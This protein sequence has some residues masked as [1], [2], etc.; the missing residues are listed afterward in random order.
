MLKHQGLGK[1]G[2]PLL[3]LGELTVQLKI[4]DKSTTVCIWHLKVRENYYLEHSK[5][6]LVVSPS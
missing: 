3:L 1:I 5:T 4:W 6:C 2:L